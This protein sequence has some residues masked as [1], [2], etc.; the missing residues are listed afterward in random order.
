MT[1]RR[2]GCRWLAPALS[3][4]F[5]M[6]S[7]L[8]RNSAEVPTSAKS[9]RHAV[10]TPLRASLALSFESKKS[11]TTLRPASPPPAGLAVEVLGAGLHA[12]DHAL[13]Q[14]GRERVVDV[15]DDGDVDLV[16]GDADLGRL[17]RVA[18]R[19]SAC[20]NGVRH[21][22]R[23][24]EPAD[25]EQCA[26]PVHGPPKDGVVHDVVLVTATTH[27]TCSSSARCESVVGKMSNPWKA[28]ANWWSSTLTPASSRRIA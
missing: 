22:E 1:R 8:V 25:D 11:T 20:G 7:T 5:T 28:P 9:C 10:M 4:Q 13:E 23:D 27:A 19:L 21:R 24:D 26:Q 18:A 17:R 16:G 6:S 2:R 14:A 15:G 12:V 3:A